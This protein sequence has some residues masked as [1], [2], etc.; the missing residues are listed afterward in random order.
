MGKSSTTSDDPVR[1]LVN[2]AIQTQ[3]L[4][5][6][7]ISRELGRNHAYI[8]QFLKAGKPRN[9]PEDVRAGLATI[10]GVPEERLRGMPRRPGQKPS[11]NASIGP[12]MVLGSDQAR[13]PVYGQAVGGKDGL[14]IFNGTKIDDALAPPMLATVRDAYAVYVAG[15]SMEPRY[16]AGETAYVHPH[17][18]V[19]R[20][21]FVVVQLRSP[22]EGDPPRGYVKEFVSRDERRL[23][24]RQL[25]P[26]KTIEFLNVDVISVHRIVLAG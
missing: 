9:L 7:A 23:R 8:F 20:G 17:L 22:D 24:L 18:P 16:R 11:P 19:R 10:I 14:F 3:G 15:E 1:T 2:E 6:A 26:K 21:D 5:M 4:D 12:R 25:N 13:I